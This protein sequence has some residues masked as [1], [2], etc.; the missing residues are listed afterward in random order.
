MPQGFVGN[1]TVKF[2]FLDCI[3]SVQI[4]H[5]NIE[6]KIK[7]KIKKSWSWG[8]VVGTTKNRLSLKSFVRFCA[9]LQS[10]QKTKGN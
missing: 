10:P 2:L 9:L 8:M 5:S 7:E 6:K 4:K 1:P 3:W